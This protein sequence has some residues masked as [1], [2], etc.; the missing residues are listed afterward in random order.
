MDEN[1]VAQSTNTTDAET[2]PQLRVRTH[3]R[4]GESVEACMNN[5]AYWQNEYYKWYEQAKYKNV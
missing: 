3:L 1:K 5:L 2:K 4:G